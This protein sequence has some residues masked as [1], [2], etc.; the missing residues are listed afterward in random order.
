MVFG[1]FVA[2]KVSLMQDISFA[3]QAELLLVAKVAKTTGDFDA[4][5][6]R[7]KGCAPYLSPV[8]CSHVFMGFVAIAV[9]IK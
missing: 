2:L 3:L 1:L 8:G 7:N 6:P 9:Y 5:A 4:P